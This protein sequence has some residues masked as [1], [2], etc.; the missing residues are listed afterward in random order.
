MEF[1]IQISGALCHLDNTGFPLFKIFEQGLMWAGDFHI[2]VES[3]Q[4]RP[5]SWTSLQLLAKESFQLLSSFR[6]AAIKGR[7]GT[8]R[9]FIFHNAK[10]GAMEIFPQKS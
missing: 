9:E 8:I 4:L 10:E 2:H 7:I 3:K 5:D 1:Y 6:Q